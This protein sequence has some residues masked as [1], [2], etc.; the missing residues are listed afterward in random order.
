MIVDPDFFDHWKTQML[1]DLSKDD[2]SPLWILRLWSF[3]QSRKTGTFD[4]LPPAAIKAVTKA[5]RHRAEQ[6]ADWLEEAGFI[7]CDGLTVV[8]HQWEE[9]NKGLFASWKNGPL[10]G[11]PKKPTGNPSETHGLPI[12]NPNET[13]VS[14]LSSLSVNDSFEEFWKAYPRK[15]GKLAAQRKWKTEKPDLE[16]CLRAIQHQ[17]QSDQWRKDGGQFIPHP[18]TWLNQGRWDDAPQIELGRRL[19]GKESQHAGNP[20]GFNEWRDENYPEADKTVPYSQISRDI[21]REFEGRAK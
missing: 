3:A 13:H 16:Q 11:R 9:Y 10:G 2:S 1:V 18:A 5:V 15:T 12:A 8:L 7:R 20:P 21:Q 6:I 4:N 19:G 14:T 17:K